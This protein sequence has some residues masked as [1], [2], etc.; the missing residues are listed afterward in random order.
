MPKLPKI[1]FAGGQQIMKELQATV[2]FACFEEVNR[3]GESMTTPQQAELIAKMYYK[4]YGRSEDDSISFSEQCIKGMGQFEGLFEKESV[5]NSSDMDTTNIDREAPFVL[6]LKRSLHCLSWNRRV[7]CKVQGGISLDVLWHKSL[8]ASKRER[9]L[10]GTLLDN[11]K[12]VLKSCKKALALVN[13]ANSPYRDGS[14]P[15]GQ[16]IEDYWQWIRH[17]MHDLEVQESSKAIAVED[18]EN[19]A[20]EFRKNEFKTTTF[21]K[22]FFVFAVWGPIVPDGMEQYKSILMSMGD[23]PVASNSKPKDGRR[24][25]RKEATDVTAVKRDSDPID[26]DRG[27]SMT[28]QLKLASLAQNMEHGEFVKKREAGRLD[29]QRQM[30][31]ESRLREARELAKQKMEMIKTMGI[32]DPQHDLFKDWMRANSKCDAI[33]EELDGI[34]VELQ[35]R[36]DNDGVQVSMGTSFLEQTL[37]RYMGPD[38]KVE[39][40]NEKRRRPVLETVTT[41]GNNSPAPSSLTHVSTGISTDNYTDENGDSVGL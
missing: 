38:I 35:Q 36:K 5:E 9:I 12:N 33:F 8:N 1:A 20:E 3:R 16:R 28:L 23:L 14:L 41:N 32:Q 25:M 15:S 40:R 17:A 29:T 19:E 34:Q 39:P 6:V 7:V 4:G 11:A 2:A 21:F 30:L 18:T 27:V 10:P 31:V 22:G 13:A 26:E 37:K 24:V